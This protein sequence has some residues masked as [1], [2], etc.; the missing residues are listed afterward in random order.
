MLEDKKQ[1]T[2]ATADPE[3]SIHARTRQS[4]S[5]IVSVTYVTFWPLLDLIMYLLR[6]ARVH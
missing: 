4:V 1:L 5:D 6:T 2:V 3:T